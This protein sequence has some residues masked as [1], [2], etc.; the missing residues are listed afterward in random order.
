[1]CVGGGSPPIHQLRIRSSA[2]FALTGHMRPVLTTTVENTVATSVSPPTS[3]VLR[4]HC[5]LDEQFHLCID[6]SLTFINKLSF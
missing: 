5:V 3:L 4:D 6:C 1:M 2:V